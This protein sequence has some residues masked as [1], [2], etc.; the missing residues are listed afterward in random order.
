V[1]ESLL[2]L[3]GRSHPELARRQHNECRRKR[4][5]AEHCQIRNIR[6]ATWARGV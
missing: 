5:I 4:R 2:F 6:V 3:L 1:F